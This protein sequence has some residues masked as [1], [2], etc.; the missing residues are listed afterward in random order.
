LAQAGF[1]LTGRDC[2]CYKL[3]NKR[4]LWV[5]KA[6]DPYF[7]KEIF[8]TNFTPRLA[9]FVIGTILACSVF[10]IGANRA[11]LAQGS[12]GAVFT[13]S[14]ATSANNV[15]FYNRAATGVLTLNGTYPTQG[16]GAGGFNSEGALIVG[17]TKK[18]L[19]VTNPGSDTGHRHYLCHSSEQP[20]FCEH[21][22]F[23]R[24]Q[25]HQPDRAQ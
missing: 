9:R 3:R 24:K 7:P 18:F 20:H 15:Y 6:R 1:A 19:Y 22:Q 2:I 12:A 10:A 13:M 8:M 14:N 23:G 17:P 21:G 4:W 11:V 25:A 5:R 16:L